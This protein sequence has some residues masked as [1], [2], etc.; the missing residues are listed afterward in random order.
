MPSSLAA[1]S[2]FPEMTLPLVGGGEVTLGGPGGWRLVIVYRG[3]HCPLCRKYL[4]GLEEIKDDFA[5]IGVDIVL[6]SGDPEEKAAATVAEWGQTLPVAYGLSLAQMHELGLYVSDP[7]SPEETD[8]PFSEP[9]LFVLNPEGA[10]QIVDLSNA[11][12]SRPD[13]AGIA[14][15]I[16][17]VREKGYPIRGTNRAAA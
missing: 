9:G 7:R 15:G 8:R 5:E 14:R 11:P 12:F 6:V 4:A 3:K 10:I 13:L 17:F 2:R 16:A 1:G